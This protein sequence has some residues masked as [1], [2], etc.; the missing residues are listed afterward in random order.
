MKKYKYIQYK[1][2]EIK[3]LD[4]IKWKQLNV[5]FPESILNSTWNNSG[6]RKKT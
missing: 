2:F 3:N 6:N 4:G 1:T 5:V